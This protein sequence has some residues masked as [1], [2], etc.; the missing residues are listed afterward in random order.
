MQS[1]V[2]EISHLDTRDVGGLLDN[3]RLDIDELRRQ[4]AQLDEPGDAVALRPN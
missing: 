3:I 4:I 1:T 2:R